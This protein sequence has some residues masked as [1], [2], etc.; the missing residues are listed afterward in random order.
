[1]TKNVLILTVGLPRSGKSTWSREQGVPIVNPDS[2]RLAIHG[3]A[4]RREAEPLVW[5][6][7][8]TMVESLFIAGHTRVIL[9]ATSGQSARRAE[10]K[11]SCWTRQYQVFD[12]SAEE[13]IKRALAGGRNY[14][15]PVIEKMA[16]NWEPIGE[17]D[18]DPEEEACSP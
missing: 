14:L 10:W 13:C 5:A 7:A 4:Y 17:D 11:S 2:I 18:L 15:V 16:A 6:V 9:D 3:Q 8:H 1:M 12:T